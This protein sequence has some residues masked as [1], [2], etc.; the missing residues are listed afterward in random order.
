MSSHNQFKFSNVKFKAQIT[1]F[2]EILP[3]KSSNKVLRKI[4]KFEIESRLRNTQ[5]GYVTKWS[6]CTPP[7]LRDL[8]SSLLFKSDMKSISLDE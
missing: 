3:E 6:F 4:T 2:G 7:L 5:V 8:A 1:Y